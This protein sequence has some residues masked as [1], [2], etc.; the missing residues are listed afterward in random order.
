MEI[1]LKICIPDGL[2][3]MFYAEEV[4]S[5]TPVVLAKENRQPLGKLYQEARYRSNAISRIRIR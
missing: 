2:L 3:S 5:I 1:L 4:I